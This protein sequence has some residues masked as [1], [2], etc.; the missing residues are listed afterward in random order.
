M[1]HTDCHV[2]T[3]AVACFNRSGAMQHNRLIAGSWQEQQRTIAAA[4]ANIMLVRF[5]SG[6]YPH[7]TC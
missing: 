5:N 1:W 7:I 4:T 6:N 3:L 2:N